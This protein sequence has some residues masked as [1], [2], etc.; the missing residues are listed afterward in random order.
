MVA[1]DSPPQTVVSHSN[2]P[3][4]K[5][6][7]DSTEP[8]TNG[9]KPRIDAPNDE[10]R[11]KGDRPSPAPGDGEN[12]SGAAAN[13]DA[14]TERGA[15]DKPAGPANSAD[16]GGLPVPAGRTSRPTT[17]PPFGFSSI[18]SMLRNEQSTDEE[19]D[20]CVIDLGM[21]LLR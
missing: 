14:P 18:F 7:E 4:R 2:S 15:E 6:R 9:K 3:K 17:P 19:F 5:A 20:G 16:Q 11:E 1:P 21:Y 8:E 10:D 13:L 12:E